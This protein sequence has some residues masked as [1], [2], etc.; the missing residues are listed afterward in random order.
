MNHVP[1]EEIRMAKLL[2]FA[3]AAV[4]VVAA[5]PAFARDPLHLVAQA[6]PEIHAD[7]APAAVAILICVALI[8]REVLV[9]SRA[10]N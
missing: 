2:N 9:R 5:T 8:V 1:T 7:S 3:A 4:V 6:A 10:A